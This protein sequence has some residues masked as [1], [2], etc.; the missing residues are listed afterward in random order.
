MDVFIL[1]LSWCLVC[2]SQLSI[3]NI[4]KYFPLLDKSQRE[5]FEETTQ[6]PTV[7]M[8]KNVRFLHAFH[9][10]EAYTKRSSEN[11]TSLPMAGLTITLE[12]SLKI[13]ET[14]YK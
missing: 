1:H 13:W 14:I 6:R 2:R 7:A 10:T 3:P 8:L 12:I 5:K 9:S 4:T 11:C